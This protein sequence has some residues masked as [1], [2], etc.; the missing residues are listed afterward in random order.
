MRKLLLTFTGA[1]SLWL[2]LAGGAQAQYSLIVN[3]PA[4]VAGGV[5]PLGKPTTT[6][7]LWG[8]GSPDDYHSLVTGVCQYVSPD[9]LAFNPPA[10]GSLTG[11][12]AV[13]HRGRAGF[14]RKVYLCQQAGAIGVIIVTTAGRPVINMSPGDSG[15]LATIPCGLVSLEW[16][17]RVRP[18]IANG[19]LNASIGDPRG[20]FGF[21]LF[22]D[23][24][25]VVRPTQTNIPRHMV[26][27]TGDL[28]FQV[29]G[30]ISNIG[31]QAQQNIRL[32]A[33][34]RRV[35]PSPRVLYL[36]SSDY[37]SIAAFNDT[38]QPTDKVGSLLRNFDLVGSD[39]NGSLAGAPGL[40]W[41]GHYQLIYTAL[42]GQ[43]DANATDNILVLD[44]YVGPR[45]YTRSRLD[46]TAT[47][48][49]NTPLY[50]LGLTLAAGGAL[51]WG[52]EFHTGSRA[53]VLQTITFAMAV[54]AANADSLGGQS[55]NLEVYRWDDADNNGAIAES[56]TFLLGSGFHEFDSNADSY[57]FFTEQVTDAANGNNGVLLLPNNRYLF[58]VNYSG[59]GT[60]YIAADQGVDYETW[61][62]QNTRNEVAL[63]LFNGV[64]WGRFSYD[65]A[66]A[67]RMD[68]DLSG[69][70]ANRTLS[71]SLTMMTVFPNPAQD[72]IQVSIGD[73]TGTGL[74]TIRIRD[75]AGHIVY[76]DQ[77]PLQGT[78]TYLKID[79]AALTVGLYNVEV[80]TGQGSKTQKLVLTR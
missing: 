17:Q 48:T 51:R 64:D 76:E 27:D 57:K 72:K 19:T 25:Q 20:Q 14:G 47:A 73:K 2:G 8:I 54:N 7:P 35:S 61:F 79:V 10:A 31:N 21:N 42:F 24:A 45:A 13:V 77:E 70:V 58:V 32:R 67:L 3:A 59:T 11:K 37:P 43:A 15:Q 38:A 5:L 22:M 26:K 80:S 68:I 53:G 60:V 1:A 12:I 62:Q 28:A 4:D 30:S 50:D 49:N 46:T 36:D 41:E 29:G 6:A 63:P 40:S 71:S 16:E 18:Y 39:P 52:H 9:T 44:F 33:M 34:V 23:K 55:A 65:Q 74:A 78:S 66:A 75:L 69:F 56:E